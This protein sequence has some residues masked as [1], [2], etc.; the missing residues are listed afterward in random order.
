MTGDHSIVLSGIS[1][2]S[3]ASGSFNILLS[4]ATGTVSG[5]LLTLTGVISGSMLDRDL[6]NNISTSQ[7]QVIAPTADLTATK[8]ADLNIAIVQLDTVTYQ[9]SVCNA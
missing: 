1:L 8:S 3:S 4:V 5:S 7:F 2:S 9:L 6:I